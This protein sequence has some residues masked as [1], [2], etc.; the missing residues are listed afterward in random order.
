[1]AFSPI[2]DAIQEF[3][4]ESNSP[5]FSAAVLTGPVE[6]APV[7]VTQATN[8]NAFAGFGVQRPNLV[9]DPALPAGARTPEEWFNPRA[10]AVA[11]VFTL[12]LSVKLLF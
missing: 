5:V 1:M 2:I 4:V 9:A 8:F 11:P 6:N 12:G 3:R 7:A 10:F